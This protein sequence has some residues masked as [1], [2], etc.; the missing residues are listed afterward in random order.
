MTSPPTCV[1][2]ANTADNAC[3]SRPWSATF[4]PS[5]ANKAAIA[6]PIPREL[7]VTKAILFFK[8]LIFVGL[9]GKRWA[10]G[11][12]QSRV[13][14]RRHARDGDHQEDRGDA[15]ACRYAMTQSRPFGFAE[16]GEFPQR[17]CTHHALDADG[18][19]R[20]ER[21]EAENMPLH[22][23]RTGMKQEPQQSAGC[24]RNSGSAHLRPEEMICLVARHSRQCEGRA[25]P[26]HAGQNMQHEGDDESDTHGDPSMMRHN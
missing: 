4:A 23:E 18:N 19:E 8:R 5:R 25:G 17:R 7:P 22:P 20:A 13:A 9:C 16:S 10:N 11:R 14:C 6:A 21:S 26:K 3:V 1:M 12:R 24:D 2:S 15:L